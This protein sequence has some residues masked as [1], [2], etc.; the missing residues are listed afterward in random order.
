MVSSF[1]CRPDGPAVT[2]K[3]V[4]LHH[5]TC[6]WT[7]GTPLPARSTEQSGP[8]AA[9][10]FA[11]PPGVPSCCPAHIPG[12]RRCR[13]DWAD[14]YGCNCSHSILPAPA[15]IRL[16]SLADPTSG[17][18]P[19]VVFW[20]QLQPARHACWLIRQCILLVFFRQPPPVPVPVPV[21]GQVR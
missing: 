12:W 2:G 18:E 16:S 17:G 13:V 10:L 21:P 7:G 8:Q 20:L 9:K 3:V 1:C 6:V 19:T 15:R 11:G 14:D 5:V 4:R